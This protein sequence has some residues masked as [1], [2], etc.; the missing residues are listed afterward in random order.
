MRNIVI[1]FLLIVISPSALSFGQTGHR[2]TGAIA[3]LNINP[4]TRHE[5]DKI[6]GNQSL[7]EASTYVDEM[8]SDPAKFW[9]KT[10]SSYHYMTIPNGKS[11]KQVGAPAQ[12]D[13]ITALNHFTKVV[14]DKTSSIKDKRIALYFIIHIIGDL[15]QPLHVGRGDDRGGN[16]IKVKFF[17]K[18]SNL[19][20]IWDS[21]MIDSKQLSY[22]EWT[23]WLNR[24]ITANNK[25]AWHTI[26]PLVW[27]NESKKI[28]EQ[29][30]P[31]K[32]Q[33]GYR[34]NY[35]HL[36]IVKKRLKQAGIRMAAYLDAL[37]SK[38]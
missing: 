37:F 11:Y 26:D 23:D 4:A 20:R 19:H 6:L 25:K 10:A 32:K 36:P 35:D 17:R 28:R 34:Y 29:I 33:I 15:H 9:Q 38:H 21:E 14:K 27:A 8:K 12:G 7:A 3:E 2:I 13:A 22:T 31:D 24:Q 5:I 30:Y 1:F 16:D 18:S